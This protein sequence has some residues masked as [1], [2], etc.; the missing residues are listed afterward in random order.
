MM[1]RRGLPLLMWVLVCWPGPLAAQAM[2]EGAAQAA[3]GETSPFVEALRS[4]IALHPA[5]RGKTAEVSAKQAAGEGAR[6]QRLPSLST[7]WAAQRGDGEDERPGSLRVRQPIW[8][9]GRIDSE[10][11]R[12]DA[13]HFAERMDLLRVQRQLLDQTVVAYVRAW[14]AR[15][16]LQVGE[17][18]VG[19]LLALSERI[20]RRARGELASTADVRLAEARLTQARVQRDRLDTEWQ[21]AQTE[22]L[23]LTQAPTDSAAPVPEALLALGSGRGLP[24]WLNDAE[25]VHADVRLAGE[26]A[27]VAEAEIERERRSGMP[28]V[29]LQAERSFN[30]RASSGQGDGTIYSVVLEAGLD[31]LGFATRGRVRGALS[32]HEAAL[33]ERASTL[34]EV[35]RTMRS[36]YLQRET[37]Q[38]MRE[39]QQ[40]SVSEVSYLLASYQRQY[41]AGYKSWLDVLNM[42]REL[43]EQRLLQVQAETDWQTYSLRLAT[44]VGAFDAHAGVEPPDEVAA[45]DPDAG[46]PWLP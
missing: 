40:Q 41:E 42:Q 34:N 28:N 32:R 31:N 18:N 26:R 36:L 43:T 39:R 11:A 14:G 35:Q 38:S 8:A 16:R 9:F 25:R 5:V 37:Q 17:E 44:L 10:I 19:E 4:T 46:L 1:R 12:A 27:R 33:A 30:E 7:Q 13:D 2:G 29:F 45:A 15:R 3:V 22:L 23:A 24:A 21:L 6:A 20:Q